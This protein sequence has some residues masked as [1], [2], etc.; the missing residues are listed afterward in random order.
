MTSAYVLF[1]VAAILEALIYV[2][3]ARL[4]GPRKVGAWLAVSLLVLSTVWLLMIHPSVGML[5]IALLSGYRMFNIFRIIKGRMHDV[6]LRRATLRTSA[7]LL[8]LQVLAGGLYL[9]ADMLQPS[10]YVLLSLLLIVEVMVAFFMYRNVVRRSAAKAELPVQHIPSHDLPSVSVVIPARNETDDLRQCI[11]GLLL[12][13]YPKLEIVVLDDCSQSTKTPEIIRNYA[14]EGVRFIKGSEPPDTWLAKNYA[15]ATLSQAASGELVLF[16]GVDIRIQPDTIRQLVLYMREYRLS[17]VSLLPHNSS[18]QRVPLLQ[19]MRYFLELAL[20]EKLL[21]SPPVLSSCWLIDRYALE[22]AG[23]FEAVRRMI[24]PE[25][26]FAE[27][28][29]NYGAYE[30]L[31]NGHLW[32]VGSSKEVAEQRATALRTI[33]PRLHRRPEMVA[34]TTLTLSF[35]IGLPVSLVIAAVLSN[36]YVLPLFFSLIALLLIYMAYRKVL[37]AAYERS[38]LLTVLSFPL[39]VIV[40]LGL[41]HY[42]MYK[43]EFSEVIWK[44]RNICISAMH[45]V[46]H[47]P[48]V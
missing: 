22:Q 7:V 25:S 17:M 18:D 4:R 40:Q 8:P 24:I 39:A 45:V 33:Y 9:L 30:F 43:Y 13:D 14:H 29:S 23:G 1:G 15:Y 20:P 6:Y 47:L 3:P 16:M 2:L 27:R 46:P 28:L 48:Q 41:M 5:L 11:D 35:L 26:Y 38:P 36:S 19:P 21:G 34:V 37:F 12:S 31:S 32:G 44:D 42:S 10:M